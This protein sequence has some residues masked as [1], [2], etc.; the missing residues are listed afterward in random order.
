MAGASVYGPGSGRLLRG[1]L[2]LRAV[3]PAPLTWDVDTAR[4]AGTRFADIRFFDEIGSTNALLLAEAR[5]SAPEGVVAVA[6]SQTAGRGRLGRVWSAAPGTSL[7]VSVLLRPRL[8]ADRLPL[9]TM[10]CGLAAADGVEQAAGFRPGLKWPNDLVAASGG[11]PDR[12][13]AGMLSEVVTGD[14]PAVVVGIGFNVSEG[15]YPPDLAGQATTC[16]AEA[17]RPVER[18]ELLVAF[19][20]ALERRYA[21]LSAPGGSEVI[22]SDYRHDSATLGR[23]VRVELAG[24]AIEGLADEIA[25]NGELIVVDDSGRQTAV[26]AGDVIHLRPS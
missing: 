18:G 16:A 6:D 26:N 11:G 13:L 23:S 7:L 4:L 2:I 1:G 9:V 24:R 21:T 3:P 17:G 25:G 22:L 20:D 15:A 5:R 8:P 19:L 10:A 14:A 12:K